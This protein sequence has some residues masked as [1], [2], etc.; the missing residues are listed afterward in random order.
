MTA[1]YDPATQ[2]TIA[3]T[4]EERAQLLKWLE[5]WLQTKLIEEHRTDA[6]AYKQLVV[7]EEAILESLIA[8]LR[9]Q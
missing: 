6:L 1:V 7:H 5:H 4:E 8:K 9:R 2:F 3:L